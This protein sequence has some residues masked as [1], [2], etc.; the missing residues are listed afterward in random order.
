[1]D[2]FIL[3]SMKIYH[4]YRRQRLNLTTHEAWKFF[5]SPYNLN[6]ITPEFFHVTITSRVPKKIYDGLMISYLMKAV[7]GIP[8]T[9]LSEI[10]Q[11]FRCKKVA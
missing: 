3:V 10:T 1:M 7:L 6:D 4:L 5:S 11:L 8:M 9:W 2:K